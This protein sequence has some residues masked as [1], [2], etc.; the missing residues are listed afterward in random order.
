MAPWGE[1]SLAEAAPLEF[2]ASA[3]PGSLQNLSFLHIDEAIHRANGSSSSLRIIACF[4]M[5]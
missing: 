3:L 2:K 1:R 5:S 4:F